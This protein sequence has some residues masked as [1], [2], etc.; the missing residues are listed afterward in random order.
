MRGGFEVVDQFE[1]LV[2]AYTGAPYAVA[3]ESC[4]SALLLCCAWMQVGTV[5]IPN[6]T[7]VSVPQSIIH[8]GG[9][10][11]F[12]DKYWR[13]LYQLKPYPI[14]DSAKRFT[15]GM[16]EQGQYMCLSF[17]AKKLLP[18]GR[19]GMILTDNSDAVE[20]FKKARH[21][22][23]Q[24]GVPLK[25]CVFDVLGWNCYMTP[26]QAARGIQLLSLYPENQRDLPY[27]DYGDLSK[28]DIFRNCE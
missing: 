10:V 6:S 9:R 11:E 8:A 1:E 21:D 12:E 7:Y 23:R 5:T 28:F 14:W 17:H 19:G 15:S 27:E 24:E 18:I 2:A 3:T 13:G 20:Y 22:G 26:E 16:Y 4:T 25:D